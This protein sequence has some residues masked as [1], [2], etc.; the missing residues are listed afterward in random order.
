MNKKY[1]RKNKG[2]G[3]SRK[4]SESEIKSMLEKSKSKLNTKSI[5]FNA[6]KNELT[7]EMKQMIDNIKKI[8]DLNKKRFD[9]NKK[10]FDSYITK[11]YKPYFVDNKKKQDDLLKITNALGKTKKYKKKT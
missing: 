3:K 6:I 2:K 10:L 7:Y 4:K 9:L 11:A 5:R 8:E 1:T